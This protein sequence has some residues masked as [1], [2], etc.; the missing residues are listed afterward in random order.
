MT[1]VYDGVMESQQIDLTAAQSKAQLR[2]AIQRRVRETEI[3]Q[4][5]IAERLGV[6][7]SAVSATLARLGESTT[8]DT[9]VRLLIALGTTPYLEVRLPQE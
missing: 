5:E 7:P 2:D 4:A 6:V 3:T 8:L 1:L 9:F